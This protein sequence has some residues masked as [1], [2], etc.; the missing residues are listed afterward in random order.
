MPQSEWIS[1][2][3]RL[4][5]D[6]LYVLVHGGSAEDLTGSWLAVA[7][8]EAGDWVDSGGNFLSCHFDGDVTHWM[9]LPAEPEVRA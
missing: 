2:G 8:Y 3:D 5:D 4:P 1:V 9:D 6:A 7:V